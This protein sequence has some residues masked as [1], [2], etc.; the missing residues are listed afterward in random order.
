[1]KHMASSGLFLRCT[2][3]RLHRP[4]CQT[5]AA[6]LDGQGCG[7]HRP[8]PLKGSRAKVERRCS[9]DGKALRKLSI[10]TAIVSPSAKCGNSR[11]PDIHS[12]QAGARRTGSLR[13]VR[14]SRTY[15]SWCASSG[16]KVTNKGTPNLM[17]KASISKRIRRRA[18][19]VPGNAFPTTR[20]FC[21]NFLAAGCRLRTYGSLLMSPFTGF[22]LPLIST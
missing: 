9:H 13:R 17:R 12:S 10:W 20:I 16:E 6:T 22:G 3:G 5:G 11:S 4:S 1:M 8:T 15:K 19:C 18:S 2:S 21:N 7:N 14:D